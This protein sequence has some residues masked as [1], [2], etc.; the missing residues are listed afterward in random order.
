MDVLCILSLPQECG[1]FTL[2]IVDLSN[3]QVTRTISMDDMGMDD[4]YRTDNEIEWKFVRRE[5]VCVSFGDGRIPKQG[6]VY[7]EGYYSKEVISSEPKCNKRIIPTWAF[8]VDVFKKEIKSSKTYYVP[9]NDK[10][11]I[12]MASIGVTGV[13]APERRDFSYEDLCTHIATQLG[14]NVKNYLRY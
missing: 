12:Y 8:D 7:E 4:C 9:E 13:S 10:F 2:D 11:A 6:D 3:G 14:Y 5:H 1:A